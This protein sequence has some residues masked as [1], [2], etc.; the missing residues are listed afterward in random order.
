MAGDW[1]RKD[2]L[3]SAIPSVGCHR[4]RMTRR[5]EGGGELLLLVEVLVVVVGGDASLGGG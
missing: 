5:F 3:A 4:G 2:G 1:D